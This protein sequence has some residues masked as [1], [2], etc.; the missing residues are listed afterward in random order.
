MAAAWMESKVASYAMHT[1]ANV[2]PSIYSGE[3]TS[4]LEKKNNNENGIYFI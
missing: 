3:K 2:C 4:A 1:S